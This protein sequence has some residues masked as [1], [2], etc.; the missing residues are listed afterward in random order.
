MSDKI[1]TITRFGITLEHET[2]NALYTRDAIAKK[3]FEFLCREKELTSEELSLCTNN[4]QI[5]SSFPSYAAKPPAHSKSSAGFIDGAIDTNLPTLTTDFVIAASVD[6]SRL[7][8]IRLLQ[9][10]FTALLS[11]F[12]HNETIYKQI[13]DGLDTLQ[14][15]ICIYDKEANLVYANLDFCNYAH[16]KNRESVYGR[17]I[18]DVLQEI[19]IKFISTKK[20]RKQMKIMDVLKYGN[21][22]LDWEVEVVSTVNPNDYQLASNDM[23]PLFDKNGDING[24]VEIARSR[25]KQIAQLRNALG[26][27]AEYTF[28]DILA[29]SKIMIETKQLAMT[30]AATSYNILIYGESGVGKEMF[31][32]SIHNYSDRKNDPFVAINCASIPSELIDSELFGYESGAFT[33]ASKKGQVGKFELANGGTLFLDEVAELPL[34]FQTKLLR[35]LETHQITRIGSSKTISVDVRILAAT[36]RSLE[37]MIEDGLFRNDLYYRLMILNI[38]IPPLRNRPEDIILYGE[39]FLRQAVE[40]SDLEQKTLDESAKTL[41]IQYDWPG[42][43]RELR[44]V[45]NRVSVCSSAP[46]ITRET[47]QASLY[48]ETY[49][50]HTLH[51]EKTPE[52]RLQEK[53]DAVGRS[54]AELIQEALCI[55]GGNKVKASELLGVSRKTFYRMLE[56]YKAFLI[57]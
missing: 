16:I 2:N 25:H 3:L 9:K 51:P 13:F 44:N 7:N 17:P 36:N 52:M 24:A 46:R 29:K 34:H 39:F 20:N 45:M 18:N 30:F 4:G 27:A 54:H 33:G 48:P 43:A 22:V 37:K 6:S 26:L 31:A 21:P 53:K 32:Q 55:S 47:L 42:N 41:M 10:A 50:L 14:T 12:T 40:K 57:T 11:I 5:L 56:K 19:G 35:T 28:D 15:S 8:E 1:D 38:E 23:Y 49:A